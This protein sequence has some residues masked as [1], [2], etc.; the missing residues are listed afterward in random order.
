VSIQRWCHRRPVIK[1]S[2]R[3]PTGYGGFSLKR[4]ALIPAPP[5]SHPTDLPDNEA[6]LLTLGREKKK[7]KKKKK[8]KK[9]KKKK[10]KRSRTPGE[11]PWQAKEQRCST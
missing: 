1:T 4:P 9:K 11:G 10:K 2:P 6:S 8:N 7:K 3:A 5:G